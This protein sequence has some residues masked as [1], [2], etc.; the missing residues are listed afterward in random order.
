MSEIKNLQAL[1][2]LDSRG[3]PTVHVKATLASG[4]TASAGVPSGAST[5]ILEAIELRDGDKS[6]YMGKGVQ[7][8]VANVNGEIL[9]A[10]QGTA[11][12]DQRALDEKMLELDGTP[13]KSRLGANALLGVSMACARAMAIETGVPLYQRLS[14]GQPFP[15]AVA[16]VKHLAADQ[17][18][19]R[20]H[21]LAVPTIE[22][23]G[24]Y[25]EFFR[26]AFAGN[27]VNQDRTRL[28]HF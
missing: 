15:H 17:A 18:P 1:E 21:A 20:P 7:K 27:V 5:G 6:R 13:N 16:P 22:G 10:L 23:S 8:A 24:G 19:W 14:T 9:T 11:A 28:C 25:V 4:A 26:K 3:N 12:D 2:I